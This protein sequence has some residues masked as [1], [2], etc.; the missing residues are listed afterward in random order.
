MISRIGPYTVVALFRIVSLI[1]FPGL[2]LFSDILGFF[3]YH[4]IRYR[5][6]VVEINLQNAF[7]EIC[8][9][10]RNA[11]ARK[12][13]RHLSDITL[14]TIK[15][16]AMTAE[17]LERRM[18]IRNPD[19]PDSYFKLHQSVIVMATHYGNWEWLLHLPRSIK[20]HHFFVY[21][22]LHNLQFDRY[23]NGIRERFGGETVSMSLILK[24]LIDANRKS[25]P[26]LTWLAAD[27][28]PPWNHPFWTTFLNQPT[29]FFNGP[30]KLARRFGCPVLFQ[31]VRRIKRGYY[32]TWFEVLTENPENM[33]VEE[34]T[35]AYVK[36]TEKMIR[37]EPSSYLWSHKRWKY[38]KPGDKPVY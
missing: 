38:K 15:T 25:I 12:F 11:I 16:G 10:K 26:V 14:E 13:Y 19:L 5:R 18:I 3:L 36:K 21:K 29:L 34:L 30:A 22:P 33:S 31:Q 6:H 35:L 20:H 9:K 28:A 24:K 27:Q 4:V 17:D 37:E 1:P 2:Y 32:E 8:R 7:P 23:L